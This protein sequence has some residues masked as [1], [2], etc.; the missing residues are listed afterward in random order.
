[1][2]YSQ[3]VAA[4]LSSLPVN[5]VQIICGRFGKLEMI[6]FWL[7]CW[8]LL[9]ATAGVK[10]IKGN[11]VRES[12]SASASD[13]PQEKQQE[14]ESHSGAV[15]ME[16]SQL[17]EMDDLTDYKMD[18]GETEDQRR[19]LSESEEECDQEPFAEYRGTKE[20]IKTSVDEPDEDDENEDGNREEGILNFGTGQD[21]FSLKELLNSSSIFESEPVCKVE[22][23]LA[24]DDVDN[25]APSEVTV[26]QE[27]ILE[28]LI[29][30]EVSSDVSTG[31]CHDLDRDDLSDCLQVEMAIVS[32]DSETD[33]QWRSTFASTVNKEERCDGNAQDAFEKDK[34]A[35]EAENG[36]KDETA[37]SPHEL[38]QPDCPTECE[39]QDQDMSSGQFKVL[40]EIPEDE[41]E[42]SQGGACKV[43]RSTSASSSV[44][45]DKKVP[46]DYCVI[47]EMTS[48]NVST[49][50]VDF[51]GA[52]KQWRQMEEQT[53]GQV[54]VHQ[55][56]VRQQGMCQGGHSAMYTPVRNID[57]PRR[58]TE[59]DSL[60]L[61]DFH[62]TQ[63]SPCSED[64]GLDDLSYRSPYEDSDNPVEREIRQTIEREENFRRERGITKQGQAGESS[65]HPRPTTLYPGKYGKGFCQEVEEKRKMFDSSDPGCRPLRSPDAKTPTFSI[66]TS[67]SPTPRCATYHE[68][69]AQ[70]VIILEPDSYPT[71]PRHRTRG[72][73]L[74]PGPSRY[75]EWPLETS[76]NV[77]ILETSNLIIRSASEFCL[78][79]ASCQETQESTFVNNPFFK[80]RSRSS[81]SLVDQEIKM[82]KQREEE[83]RRQRSQMHTREKYDTVVVS[84]NLENLSFD[85]AE[86][87]LKC[88]SSPSSPSRTRKLDRS[89]LSCD[90]RFPESLSTLPRKK[91][92]M[93]Q[94][95]E[96]RLFVNHE[97]E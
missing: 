5:V 80:L 39:I 17:S 72:S 91:N 4:W 68:M 8:R 59:L 28:Q 93:A 69:T 42:A 76:A 65:A 1:M 14:Q 38:E 19:L 46:Q 51:Q 10:R 92:T 62:H 61:G 32:S 78:S 94:R 31:S 97:Q 89:T 90:H 15:A 7:L 88:V 74:S 24:E 56:T 27:S 35:G 26:T 83:W 85:T 95:W 36:T 50:H 34:A 21:D 67:P 60:A 12:C 71:S 9:R 20:N 52:R 53:K 55:P 13:T 75:S 16:T 25:S 47:Q 77:I 87:P 44:S 54:Q 63:F 33:D 81:M 37:D 58:D 18:S 3:R 22:D 70:N 41:E 66:A 79:S 84:P 82:V 73:L 48:K 29:R 11:E 40:S 2:N 64:S 30:E 86:V 57:R 23:L 45:S 96:A 43:R 6:S 49:E